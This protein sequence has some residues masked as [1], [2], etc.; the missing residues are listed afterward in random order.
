MLAPRSIGVMDRPPEIFEF[1]LPDH[2]HM[3]RTF[4][5]YIER[6]FP[7]EEAWA[8]LFDD[9][10]RLDVVRRSPRRPRRRQ[11]WT[12]TQLTLC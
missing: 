9:N 1:A 8:A 6:L 4:V 3:A 7:D 2:N 5:Y 10:Q 11:T 12:D